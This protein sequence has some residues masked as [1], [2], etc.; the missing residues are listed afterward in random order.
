MTEQAA[1]WQGN[2]ARV[3]METSLRLLHAADK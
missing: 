1:G 3:L 2:G